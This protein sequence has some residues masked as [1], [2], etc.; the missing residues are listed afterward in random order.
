M[1]LLL[2]MAPA[3]AAA[4]DSLPKRVHTIVQIGGVAL[5]GRRTIETLE[6]V[7]RASATLTGAELFI[8]GDVGLN[9]RIVRGDFSNLG[10]IQAAGGFLRGHARM[11]FGD[12]EI[13][14]LDLGYV[15]RSITKSFNDALSMARAGGRSSLRLGESGFTAI[16]EAGVYGM[17]R[18][19]GTGK[20]EAAMVG[21][22]LESALIYRLP[23]GLPLYLKLGYHYERFSDKLLQP[24]RAEEI[25]SVV[26]GGG[27]HLGR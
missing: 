2:A 6:G 11:L 27:L 15:R 16:I 26:F 13:F 8:V 7:G 1:A 17:I 3:A 14:K 20:S 24:K 9:V 22:D 18:D 12:G 5:S 10:G 4:Q 19:P 25:G 23:R 21:G